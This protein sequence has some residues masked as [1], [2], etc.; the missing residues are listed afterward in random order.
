MTIGCVLILNSR[1]DILCSRNYR[2][3]YNV[4]TVGEP[5]RTQ[6][7]MTKLSDRSP[8]HNIGGV[9]YMFTRNDNVWFVCC[10][11]QNSNAALVFQFMNK[12]IEIFKRYFGEFN[13]E[14]VR[15][16]HVTILELLDEVLDYGYPQI[17]ETDILQLYITNAGMKAEAIRGTSESNKQLSDK[18]TGIIGWR[19]EGIKH[20]KNEVFIDVVEEVNVLIASNGNVLQRDVSGRIDMKSFLSGMPECK[21]GLNDRLMVQAEASK[22]NKHNQIDLED[23]TFHQC[24]RLGKFES[25]RSISFVPPDGS[26]QLMK[27]RTTENVSP[28]FRLTHPHYAQRGKTRIEIQFKLKGVFAGRLNATGVVVKVPCP[29]NTASCKIIVG[30]GKAKYEP[31]HQA[32][33]WRIKKFPG[34]SEVAFNADVQLVQ[35]THDGKQWSKP[36]ISL[37]FQVPM[38]T[39]SGLH[40]RFL[41]V[42]EPKLQYQAVKW[43]RY[44]SKAGQYECRI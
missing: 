26:F 41:K 28:P 25:N 16:N 44:I 37:Q 23:T 22:S 7:I 2:D 43:V 42:H 30:A 15:D 10:T 4:R 29:K 11:K 34:G 5:F 9:S 35:A 19:K 36:P 12:T 8:V 14:T 40:V 1:G 32:I 31:E 24:V 18:V 38:L 27:Y 20:K 33:L 21:F 39:T 13:E 17:T 6:V 3:L